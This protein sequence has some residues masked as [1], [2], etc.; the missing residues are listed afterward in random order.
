MAEPKA[1]KVTERERAVPGACTAS[2]G[3]RNQFC[4]VLS[5]E[6]STGQSLVLGA[7]PISPQGRDQR[8]REV[9]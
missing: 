6:G 3:T 4:R 8:A 7:Q 2:A 9:R 5:A 1:G